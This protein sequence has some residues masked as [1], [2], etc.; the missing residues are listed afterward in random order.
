MIILPWCDVESSSQFDEVESNSNNPIGVSPN[1]TATI[2][3]LVIYYSYLVKLKNKDS[4]N[5]E[6]PFSEKIEGLSYDAKKLSE[7]M[8]EEFKNSKLY[9]EKSEKERKDIINAILTEKE[10]SSD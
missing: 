9:T 3:N 2:E 4:S 7:K 10:C 6:D 8:I 5:P 1:R